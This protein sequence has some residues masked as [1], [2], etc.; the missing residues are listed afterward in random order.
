MERM[1]KVK[2][3]E[4]ILGVM[5]MPI[6]KEMEAHLMC[7]RASSNLDWVLGLAFLT[8]LVSSRGQMT[9]SMLIIYHL[10]HNIYLQLQI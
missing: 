7:L 9:K 6:L 1:K 8:L 2:V 3:L 5:R 4:V 10:G